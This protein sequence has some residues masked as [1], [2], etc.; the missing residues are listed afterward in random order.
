MKYLGIDYGTKRVGIAL[1]D[2][3]GLMAYPNVVLEAN[4]NLADEVLNITKKEDVEVI[5]VGESNNFSGKPNPIMKRIHGFCAELS[6]KT[7]L[8]VVFEPE[9]LTSQEAK[10]IQGENDLHDASAAAV[11]LQSYLDRVRGSTFG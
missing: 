5:V 7:T 2:R 6:G 9:V 10:H 4:K 1:S 3:E 8:S 11:M